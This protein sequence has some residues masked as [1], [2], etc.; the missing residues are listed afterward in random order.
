M[1]FPLR[2]AAL[3]VFIHTLWG[4]NPVAVKYGLWV[5]PPLWTGFFRFLIAI[6]CIAVWARGTGVPIWP[7]R[8]EWP[9]LLWLGVLFTVQIAAMNIGFDHTTAAMGAVLIATNPLFASVFAHF[10]LDEDRLS[11]R[12]ALGLIVAFAGTALVLLR[13]SD[14]G[15]LS[16]VSWGNWIVL[17][18]AVLLG[19]R[20]ILSAR[21]LRQVDEVRVA[22]WQMVVALP[23]FAAGGALLETIRWENL[24]WEPLAAIVYQGAVIAGFG[25]M[26]NFYLMKRYTPS[27][28]VSF[29]FVSPIAGVLLAV[30]L[31]ADP[32]TGALLVGL[33]MVAAGLNLV[34]R[35]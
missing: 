17:L 19:S 14:P 33:A 5:F 22:I 31:L 1:K 6:A 4:A 34:A 27:V 23:L 30:W 2:A 9:A 3:A 12:K 29:N 24:S 16:L 11:L 32:L 25:F 13:G 7:R 28:V 18:S 8:G 20:L 21:I 26:A 10:M 15:Q 35:S